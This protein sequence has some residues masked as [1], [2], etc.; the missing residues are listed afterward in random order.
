MEGIL[1]GLDWET[2]GSEIVTHTGNLIRINT[3][4]PPGNELAAARYIADQFDRENINSTILESAP[5]RASLIARIKGDGSQKP[6]LLMSHLDVVGVEPEKWTH[7]PFSAQISDGFMWGRGTLDCK[8][9]VA[10]WMMVMLIMSREKIVPK[11]DVIF[12]AAADEETGGEYGAKWLVDNHFDLIDAEAALNEGGGFGMEFMGKTFF[13]YQTAEKGNIWLRFTAKGTA[14]HA[15]MPK[16]DNPVLKVTDLVNRLSKLKL[17]FS[18][19]DTVRQMVKV[20]A[21][22]QGFPVGLAMKQMLNRYLSDFIISAAIKDETIAGGFRAMLNNTICPTVLKAGQKVNVIP[23]QALVELDIRVLP[24]HD[25]ERM[26]AFIKKTAGNGFDVEVLDQVPPT[27]SRLDHPLSESI[28]RAVKN[29]QP[30]SV[31]TPLL[32]PGSSDGAFLRSKGVVVYG[33]TPV[34]P[35]DDMDLAHGHDERISLESL[36]FSLEVGLETVLDFVL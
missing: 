14:G 31:L 3:V 28:R 2:Y 18:V 7:D 5:G 30:D 13:T 4:N 15:S 36:R 24:G 8:N 17:G 33:F 9:S 1:Q 16:V 6:L 20:M 23:S 27:E 22:T 26:L 10:L 34:L 21:S 11:R 19:I 35:V 25:Q 32:L 29:H 12:L